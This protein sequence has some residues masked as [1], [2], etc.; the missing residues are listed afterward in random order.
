MLGSKPIKTPLE[1]NFISNKDNDIDGDEHLVNIT[2]FQK[3]IGK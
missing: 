3:L 2:E 1:A